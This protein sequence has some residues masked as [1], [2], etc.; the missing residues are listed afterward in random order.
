MRTLAG[1]VVLLAGAVLSGAGAVAE[2]VLAAAGKAGYAPAADGA[3][4]AGAIV[5]LAGIGLLVS[6]LRSE[7]PA[8]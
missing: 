1:A 4:W 3:V 2:A 5:A 8:R 6:G 7:S